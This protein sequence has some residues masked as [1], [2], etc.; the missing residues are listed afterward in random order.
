MEDTEYGEGDFD[1]DQFHLALEY[2][3]RR[4]L[5]KRWDFS[6]DGEIR[7]RYYTTGN[8]INDDP[9][10]SGRK[11]TRWEIVPGASVRIVRH[12]WLSAKYEYEARDTVS[13]E[14]AVE[15]AKDFTRQAFILGLKYEFRPSSKR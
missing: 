8:S 5:G 12:L 1:E 7:L 3:P 9:F 14:P 10:H 11:D 13:D 15:A 2:R 4:F 6:L